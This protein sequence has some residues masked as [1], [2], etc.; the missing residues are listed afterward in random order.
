[1]VLTCGGTEVGTHGLMF[2]MQALMP[3]GH[4]LL[5]FGFV[6]PASLTCALVCILLGFCA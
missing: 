5:V 3:A 6:S 2:C 1:M 4:L